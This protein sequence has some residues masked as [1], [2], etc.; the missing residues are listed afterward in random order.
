MNISD[1][2]LFKE[3]ARPILVPE[4]RR[5]RA[6]YSPLIIVDTF[7][8]HLLDTAKLE[9]THFKISDATENSFCITIQGRLVGTGT[10]SSTIDTM[11]ASLSFNGFSFAKVKLPQIQTSYW[12]TDF[13]VQEQRV[14]ISDYATYCNFVRSLIVDKDTCLQLQNSECTI[15]ALGASPTCSIRI[16]MPLEAVDGPR[17]AIRKV[18]R[19]GKHVRMVLSLSY[20]GPV[21]I[22][23]GL[24]LFELRNGPGEILAELKGDLTISQSQSELVLHGTANHG[25]IPSQMV[26]L[27]GV[28]AEEDKRSWLNETIKEVDVVFGL[29]PEHAETLWF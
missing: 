11:E 7:V 23:H 20:S 4:P 16:D 2:P 24:C 13:A 8:Q 28:G 22:S 19:S 3:F 27:I 6:F 29:E 17:L 1:S 15:R 9:T 26:R 25:V 5:G 14:Y 10:I 21:E 12:G 18:S